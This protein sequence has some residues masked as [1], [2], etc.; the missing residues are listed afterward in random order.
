MDKRCE[1]RIVPC[2]GDME[3]MVM[4][5]IFRE[6]VIQDGDELFIWWKD[7]DCMPLRYCPSCGKRITL[8]GD[9]HGKKKTGEEA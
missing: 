3:E 2:C 1:L 9:E 8:R 6:G 7:C 4:M 5:N